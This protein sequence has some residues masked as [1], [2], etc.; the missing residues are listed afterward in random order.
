M[1][2]TLIF[3]WKVLDEPSFVKEAQD[4]SEMAYFDTVVGACV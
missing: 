1:Q 4:N 2:I 3:I